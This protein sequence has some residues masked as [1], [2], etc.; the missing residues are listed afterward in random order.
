MI[1]GLTSDEDPQSFPSKAY[2]TTVFLWLPVLLRSLARATLMC[3][4]GRNDS[5]PS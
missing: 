3:T 2:L 5:N 4:K 1:Y